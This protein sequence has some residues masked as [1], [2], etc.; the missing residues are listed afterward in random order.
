MVWLGEVCGYAAGF[1]YSTP[2]FESVLRAAAELRMV[3]QIHADDTREM[4]RLCE[5]HP[6][7]SFVL[8][9]LGNSPQEV[10]AR[11]DLA[12]GTPN[13]TLDICGNGF[14]RMGI[15]ELAVEKVGV[16]RLLFGSDYTLNDPGGVIARVRLSGLDPQAK[17]QILGGNLERLLRAHGWAGFQ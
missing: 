17:A 1:E 2:G 11:I 15:L 10:V 5:R 14:E 6:Q 12:A 4:G 9:H 13:L 16:E 8:A 3:V 7:I